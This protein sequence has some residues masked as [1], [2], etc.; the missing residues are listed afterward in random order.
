MKTCNW[1][2]IHV[3]SMPPFSPTHQPTVDVFA[4][5]IDPKMANTLVRKLNQIA[6]L[7]TF[8]HVKRVRKSSSGG[9]TELSVI[10]CLA[11]ENDVELESMP[12]DVR[13][14]VNS[15][16]LSPFVTQ[17]CKYAATKKE[18]WEEQCKLWPTSFHPPTYNIEGITG[19][20][21]EDSK[22]VFKHMSFAV[23]L[24]KSGGSQ[25]A[26]AA[27][28]VDPSVDQIIASAHDEVSSWLV[29]PDG[30]GMQSLE[31]DKPS[32]SHGFS[33]GSSSYQSNVI[34]SANDSKT[35]HRGVCCLNPWQWSEQHEPSSGS[36]LWHPLRHAAMVAIEHSSARDR[37]LFP[38]SWKSDEI[39]DEDVPM[40]NSVV[41]SQAKRQKRSPNNV[42]SSEAAPMNDVPSQSDRPY[43][44]TGYDVYVAW[45]PCAM[46][47]MALLHQRVRRIFYAL[48][49]PSTGALGSVYR[50]QGEKSLNHH[51][52]VFQVILHDEP[53]G[54]AEESAAVALTNSL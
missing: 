16:Q 38:T 22:I 11:G 42:K 47:A 2:I 7:E 43:L 46:C 19:F 52:A 15:N 54:N 31:A 28:I 24:A 34:G 4:S 17:V 49:N 51:Y 35:L 18:E 14:L 12:K 32:T 37:R 50:L 48:P 39:S 1:E 36:C 33:N 10:L 13:E 27:V 5:V 9:K 45:E 44:C 41:G 6:P 53:L 30:N 8:R 40:D 25:L 26:N 3:P 23:K 21:E 20:S 29:C